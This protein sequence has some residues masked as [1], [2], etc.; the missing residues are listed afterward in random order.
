MSDGE[1]RAKTERNKE[2]IK[3]LKE[4]VTEHDKVKGERLAKLEN[5]LA[6]TENNQQQINQK[7]DSLNDQ[8]VW[9]KRGVWTIVIGQILRALIEY[10]GG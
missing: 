9:F 6:I 3:E 10:G 8:L 4:K 1:L 7:L 5:R 2:D